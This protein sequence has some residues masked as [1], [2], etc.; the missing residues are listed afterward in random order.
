MSKSNEIVVAG[1]I[2]KVPNVVAR[3]PIGQHPH[4]IEWGTS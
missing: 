4:S 2:L 3:R 1:G